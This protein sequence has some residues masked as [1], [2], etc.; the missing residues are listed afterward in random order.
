MNSAKYEIDMC[1]GPLAG[2]MLLFAIPLMVS[3][4]I[5]L[6]FNAVDMIVV[7]RFVSPQALAAVGS[8]GPLIFLLT[9]LFMGLSVGTNILTAQY[10]G[11]KKE[12]QMNEV[13][14]TS[15]ALG[16]ISGIFLAGL[17]A[18]LARPLLQLMGS[19]SDVLDLS[20]LYL[21]I[22]NIKFYKRQLLPIDT[23]YFLRFKI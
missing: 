21:R 12:P 7:G 1:N 9:S 19:P 6:L 23:I 2:K 3:G 13:I 18:F 16:L 4:V 22:T 17:G 20:V 10:Y 15:V 14:H 11:A 8:A 5:Q